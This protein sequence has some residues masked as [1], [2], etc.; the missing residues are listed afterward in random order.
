M[1]TSYWGVDHGFDI[2]KAFED[3]E[4]REVPEEETPQE[5]EGEESEVNGAGAELD[6][7]LGVKDKKDKDKKKK[8]LK[9][10]KKE[11][12]EGEEAPEG[13]EPEGVPF[14]KKRAP[15]GLARTLRPKHLKEA[16]VN[17]GAGG[18]KGSV[19]REQ[20]QRG[21]GNSL[22]TS[23]RATKTTTS[24]PI[25]G[26]TKTSTV[27]HPAALTQKG[28]KA[29]NVAGITAGV[30]GYTGMTAAASNAGQRKKKKT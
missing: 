24:H 8:E 14:I 29:R 20:Y 11:P 19:F 27:Y 18:P 25:T 16:T 28:K 2:S 3:D 30:G 23:H 17:V 12:V 13:E 22:R 1:A 21:R 4:E 10:R 7:L 6:R 9:A 5:Q 26:N 15:R